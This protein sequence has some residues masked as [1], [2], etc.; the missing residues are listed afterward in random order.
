LSCFSNAVIYSKLGFKAEVV[1]V[2]FRK[3]VAAKVAV[4]DEFKPKK[5]KHSNKEA[6]VDDQNNQLDQCQR[7]LN[8]QKYLD[9]VMI[10]KLVFTERG[11]NPNPLLASFFQVG[12][13][14]QNHLMYIEDSERLDD[15]QAL[16][17]EQYTEVTLIV[18]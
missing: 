18:H 8:Y 5:P 14:V 11:V 7:V 12:S 17:D 15:P 10:L 16:D 13:D 3:A 4:V 2:T 1:P 9:V 6:N